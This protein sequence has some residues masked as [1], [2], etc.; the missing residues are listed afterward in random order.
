MWFRRRNFN[1]LKIVQGLEIE[2]AIGLCPRNLNIFYKN[3]SKVHDT[4]NYQSSQI[5][6]YD[7]FGAQVSQN[8][9]T[10]VLTQTSSKTMH[11]IMPNECKWLLVLSWIII[12]NTM[13]SNFYIFKGKH[14][15]H[16]FIAKCEFGVTMAMWP[17]T[18]MT[19]IL[20][21]KWIHISLFLFKLLKIIYAQLIIPYSF[22][23]VRTCMLL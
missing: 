12:T 16:C 7:E 5:W 1:L 21:N 23:M 22:C 17:K 14:L 3:L 4:H 15:K 19:S 9:S 18:W 20:F 11:S 2:H 6:N 8:G 13:F 10:L